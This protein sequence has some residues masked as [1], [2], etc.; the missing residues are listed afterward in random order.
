MWVCYRYIIGISMLV[1]NGNVSRVYI[2]FKE[3]VMYVYEFEE[4][5]LDIRVLYKPHKIFRC[6]GSL[7][8][9]SE[10]MKI[11]NNRLDMR[12]IKT[13]KDFINGIKDRFPIC[14]IIYFCYITLFNKKG[15]GKFS[16]NIYGIPYALCPLCAK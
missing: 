11:Y 3:R 5:E 2:L 9:F 4:S 8:D 15:L 14:C 16:K 6:K 13:L 1:D 7:K 10:Q 12:I